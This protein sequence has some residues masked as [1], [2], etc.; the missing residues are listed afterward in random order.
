MRERKRKDLFS[1]ET[2][3]IVAAVFLEGGEFE[4]AGGRKTRFKRSKMYQRS[5]KQ[6]EKQKNS[7]EP[8]ESAL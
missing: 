1:T 8:S 5:S 3:G 6:L 2:A 7:N 4:S